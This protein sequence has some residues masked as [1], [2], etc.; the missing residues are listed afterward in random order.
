MHRSEEQRPVPK[1]LLAIGVAVVA[2]AAYFAAYALLATRAVPGGGA[3]GLVAT[4]RL[5]I[6]NHKW[7]AAVFGPAVRVE[8][9]LSSTD[10]VI[11]IRQT[12]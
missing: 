3:P 10:L 2:V 4:Q 6:F 1:V 8:A 5:R 7:Q 11:G 9:M 12:D